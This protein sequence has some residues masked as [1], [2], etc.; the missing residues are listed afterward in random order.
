MQPIPPVVNPWCNQLFLVD[1]AYGDVMKRRS[2][3]G[4]ET[5]KSRRRKPVRLK[6]SNAAKT[7]N[8]RGISPTTEEMEVGRLRRELQEALEQRTASNEVLRVISGSPADVRS[9][10]DMIVT[11]AVRLCG[12]RMGAVFQ[13]D[14]ALIHLVA[15][16]NYS[17]EVLRH[18]SSR[19]LL[20]ASH[21]FLPKRSRARIRCVD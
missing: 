13:F 6:R 14:G 2:R 17:P 15:H 19:G 21:Q 1:S 12:A 8:C 9:A 11:S 18:L 10:F 4:G 5:A 20:L 7:P 16:H 3:V